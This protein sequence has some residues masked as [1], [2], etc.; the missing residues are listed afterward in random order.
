NLDSWMCSRKYLKALYDD[1][2][3]EDSLAIVEGVMGLYDG[4]YAKK[5][6]GSTAEIAGLLGLPVILIINGEAMARS[7]AALVKGFAE[8]DPKVNLIG[9]IA[10]RVNS[11]GHAAILKDAIHHHTPV[12]F[13][14]HVPSSPLLKMESRHLGLYQDHEQ[15]EGFYDRWAEHIERHINIKFI[16]KNLRF[17]TS[18]NKQTQKTPKRF[19]KSHKGS[20]RVGVARDEAFRFVYQDTLDF[21][22][23]R[24]A[25]VRFF[26]PLRNKK[27]PERCDWLYIP[28]GYPELHAAELSAN[29]SMRSAL[30]NFAGSGKAL[31]AECGG[32]MYLGNTLVDE[33]GQPHPMVGLYKFSTSMV[34]KK[35]TLGYRR[36]NFEDPLSAGKKISLRGHEFH[37]STLIENQETPQM[38]MPIPASAPSVQDGFIYKNCF[39]FYSHL[40]WPAAPE[41]LKFILNLTQHGHEA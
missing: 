24:G 17:K 23:H 41:W 20:F 27:L 11:P 36:L 16:L 3:E 18:A 8:F 37:Y 28:G 7:A 13:L 6:T 10:N 39:S 15:D 34:D 26:S 19:G 22:A 29:R 21:F 1:V 30:R 33:T 40:Y 9:V 14:G 38:S 2:M 12:K 5:S 4:A 35:L 32:L 25:D 31:V